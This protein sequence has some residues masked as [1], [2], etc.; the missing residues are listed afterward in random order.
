MS[1]DPDCAGVRA[2]C[3]AFD[4]ALAGQKARFAETFVTAAS[5]GCVLTIMHNAHY[6]S[7]R[8]YLF[9]LARELKTEYEF[10]VSRG[11]LLQIDAPDLA[12]ERYLYFRDA[13]GRGLPHPRRGPHRGA[14]PGACRC[15]A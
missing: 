1:Y 15:A 9:A 14:Q 13:S 2:E 10:I 8:D 5:P 12:M 7:D 11:H 4:D 3:D 6:A